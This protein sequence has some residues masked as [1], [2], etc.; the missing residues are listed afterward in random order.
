VSSGPASRCDRN[1]QG[2]LGGGKLG[3]RCASCSCGRRGHPRR[4]WAVR[5]V[6]R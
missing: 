2:T 6:R 3:G 4:L 1:M 5:P